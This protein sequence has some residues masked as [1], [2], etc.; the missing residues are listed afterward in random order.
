MHSDTNWSW[1]KE[2]AATVLAVVLLYDGKPTMPK[3]T[4]KNINVSI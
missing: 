3:N 4:G 2:R 1:Q